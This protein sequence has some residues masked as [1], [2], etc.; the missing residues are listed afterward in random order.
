MKNTFFIFAFILLIT[1]C[2]KE[3][4]VPTAN[5]GIDQSIKEGAAVTLDG[6]ASSD[7]DGDALT[8]KW[9][10]PPGITL[11]SETIA[12]PTFVAPEVSAET[13]YTF[14]LVVNDGKA[15][16]PTDEVVI[17]T[18]NE[19]K[20]LTYLTAGQTEG[21]GINYV[22]FDPDAKLVLHPS[23]YYIISL[24]LDL[25]NDDIDD[26]ELIYD[27]SSF[28]SCCYALDAQIIP[29]G[30]NS[31]CVS[32]TIVSWDAP[33]VESLALGDTIG[34]NNNWSNSKAYLFT[35]S[36]STYTG[37]DGVDFTQVSKGGYWYKQDNLFMGVKIIK[38]GKELFSWIDVKIDVDR[39]SGIVRRYSVTKPY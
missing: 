38:E 12:Q 23:N 16:S 39:N 2:T 33:Y 36:S 18:A 34:T 13:K 37:L 14:S 15:N 26:F 3:N 32:K 20:F 10:A 8:Y 9:T 19:D 7:P 29:L 11:S 4:K 17:T 6:S 30:K 35:F 25:N 24:K 28:R 21:I 31:I 27:F 1:S 22:D 5:A